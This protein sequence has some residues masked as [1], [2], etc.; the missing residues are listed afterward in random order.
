MADRRRI[1][2]NPDEPRTGDFAYQFYDKAHPHFGDKS[3]IN[4]IRSQLRGLRGR[5]VKV[6]V[7][8]GFAEEEGTE[9]PRVFQRTI[10]LNRYGDIF[11]PGGAYSEMMHELRNEH[12]EAGLYA[13]SVDVIAA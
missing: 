6:V 12:S 5:R 1:V 4:R 9:T 2:V 10:T 8:A 13:Y 3:T 7:H 11:G